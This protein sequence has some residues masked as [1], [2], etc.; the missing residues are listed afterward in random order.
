MEYIMPALFVGHASVSRR[1]AGPR[2]ARGEWW[3]G[4][5][6]RWSSFTGMS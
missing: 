6:T 2:R 3:A 4:A 5:L 1:G